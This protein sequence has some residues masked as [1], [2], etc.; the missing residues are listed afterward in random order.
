MFRASIACWLVFTRAM[1]LP[2]IVDNAIYAVMLASANSSPE[3]RGDAILVV[4]A[5]TPGIG[6]LGLS[7]HRRRPDR[8][9]GFGGAIGTLRLPDRRRLP[10]SRIPCEIGPRRG[11]GGHGLPIVAGR[12]RREAC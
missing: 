1:T 11:G 9:R 4:V 10:Q 12:L 6:T 8:C 5:G 2:M 3:S 7:H